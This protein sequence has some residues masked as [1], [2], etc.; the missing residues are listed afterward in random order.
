MPPH[1]ES[2][3]NIVAIDMTTEPNGIYFIQMSDADKNIINKK[4]FKQERWNQNPDDSISW[5]IV[6]G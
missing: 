6:E 5:R 1:K 3:E 4:I 2:T